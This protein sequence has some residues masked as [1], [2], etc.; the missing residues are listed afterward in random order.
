MMFFAR[1]RYHRSGLKARDLELVL[2]QQKIALKAAVETRKTP[3]GSSRDQRCGEDV[4]TF[5][6]W[7]Y[8]PIIAKK[9]PNFM[10]VYEGFA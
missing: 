7:P 6:P 4:V 3:Q 2:H 8:Y 10:H 5:R 1:A 9:L